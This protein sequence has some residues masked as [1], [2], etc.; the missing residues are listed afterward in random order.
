MVADNVTRFGLFA[1]IGLFVAVEPAY[2]IAPSFNLIGANIIDSV[3]TVPGMISGLSYLFGMILGVGGIID[4]K[5]HV[6]SPSNTPLRKPVIKLL[7]GGALFALPIIFE[8]MM[9]SVNFGGRLNINQLNLMTY[10]GLDDPNMSEDSINNIFSNIITSSYLLPGFLSGITYLGG[11]ILGVMAIFKIKEHV[12]NPDQ[13]PIREGVIR[14]LIG[15]ALFA[16]P[17]IVYAMHGT[18]TGSMLAQ[19]IVGGEDLMTSAETGE[20][21]NNL[22]NDT[23]TMGAVVCLLTDNTTALPALLS[24]TAYLFGLVLAVWGLY[25][26]RDHVLNPGNTSI[27][28]GAAKLLTGGV[29]FSLPMIVYTVRSSL[30]PDDEMVTQRIAS[31]FNEEVTDTCD[32]GL[33]SVLFCFMDDIFGPLGIAINIFAV[34]SGIILIMVGIS[35]LIKGANEGA[36]A[37]GGIGT[38]MTFITGGALVSSHSLITTFSASLFAKPQTATFA[39]LAFTDGMSDD[40]VIH[41]H[42]VISAILKFMFIIGLISFA[43]GIYIIRNVAEGNGQASIMAGVTHLVGGALAVNLGPLMAA[44]QATL[45]ITGYGIT[46]E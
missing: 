18:I 2:A 36:K 24:A 21:C 13:V 11:M 15:G 34:I 27:W 38:I 28:E 44:V 43:R 7:A 37:P 16:L 25:K 33:D 40:E 39:E 6:E 29:F 14:L 26:I 22:G 35:R 1:F 10:L 3:S 41:A 42:T 19:N 23:L 9:G 45:N 20:T 17:S 4:M 5:N 30:V 31:G 8:A 12:E 32:N 46:F